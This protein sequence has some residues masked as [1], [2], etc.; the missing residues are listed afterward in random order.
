MLT[1]AAMYHPF[2][3]NLVRPNLPL[4]R[5]SSGPVTLCAKSPTRLATPDVTPVRVALGG[6]G[7]G[8]PM[9]FSSHS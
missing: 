4:R 2:S 1:A 5:P 7:E 9:P 6:A 3:P 8:K